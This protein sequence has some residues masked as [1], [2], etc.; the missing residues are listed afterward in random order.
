MKKLFT[1]ILVISFTLT[2]QSQNVYQGN[3]FIGSNSSFNMSTTQQFSVKIDGEAVDSDLLDDTKY[4]NTNLGL[5][6]GYFIA[7]YLAVG[8]SVDYASAKVSSGSTSTSSSNITYSALL[9]YYIGGVAFVEG[10]YGSVSNL[11]SSID[12]PKVSS[13]HGKVGAS[14]FLTD[15][16]AFTPSVTYQLVSTNADYFNVENISVISNLM[17]GAGITVYL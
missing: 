14:I 8:I 3:F 13:M 12:G 9:R 16:V 11:D 17:I 15:E 7:D 10:S 2:I 6:G 4:T 5:S 1:T